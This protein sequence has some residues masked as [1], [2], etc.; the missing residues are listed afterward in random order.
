MLSQPSEV[1]ANRWLQQ[2]RLSEQR[3]Q[4]RRQ[5]LDALIM[6]LEMPEA[7]QPLKKPTCKRIGPGRYRLAGELIA[8]RKP[9]ATQHL[10][11][12]IVA[13]EKGHDWGRIVGSAQSLWRAAW[14]AQV[15]H[16]DNIPHVPQMRGH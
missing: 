10:G 13:P 8:S 3:F 9:S 7:I 4:T 16:D 6:A 14:I 2:T 1:E 11:W 12:D 15:R 5:A